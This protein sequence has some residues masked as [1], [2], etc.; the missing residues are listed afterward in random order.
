MFITNDWS[1]Y[2]DRA[3]YLKKRIIINLKINI[4]RKCD[5]SVPGSV[6]GVDNKVTQKVRKDVTIDQRLYT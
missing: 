4:K 5:W 2:I 6:Y 3:D 1:F